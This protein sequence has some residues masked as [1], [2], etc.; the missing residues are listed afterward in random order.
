MIDY[1]E[2][3]DYAEQS[4]LGSLILLSDP[5]SKALIKTMS[6]LKE[7][8]FYALSH[9]KIF[10]AV[11]ALYRSGT[12]IDLLTL[13]SQCNRM[14]NNDQGLFI[15]LAEMSRNTPSAA[16]IINYANIVRECAIE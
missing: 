9:R 16:N 4:V 1:Q 14:G 7:S 6:L 3:S 11:N 2:D 13:E 15:Y 8:S 12:N 5:N 10:S